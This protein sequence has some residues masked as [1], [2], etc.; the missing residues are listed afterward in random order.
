MVWVQKDQGFLVNRRSVKG[1][2]C[3]SV[4]CGDGCCT[5]GPPQ[6][7]G[8]QSGQKL[9]GGMFGHSNT[10]QA[11]A[12]A[13]MRSRHGGTHMRMHSRIGIAEQRVA[14]CGT[15]TRLRKPSGDGQDHKPKQSMVHPQGPR[16]R[17]Y[18]FLGRLLSPVPV[19]VAEP[20]SSNDCK[21]HV[22]DTEQHQ[23]FR[24]QSGPS[25]RSESRGR[26][27][28]PGNVLL[29]PNPLTAAQQT[30]L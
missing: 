4:K 17:R 8:D 28:A 16:G 10:D 20:S 23:E 27:W 26:A 18:A 12:T 24:G 9:M 7:L 29:C 22:T 30:S 2:L 3:R 14:D 11:Q 6:C 1:E 15:H 19:P 5:I 13:G 21:P 25:I